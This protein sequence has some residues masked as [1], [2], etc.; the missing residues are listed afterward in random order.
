MRSGSDEASIPARLTPVVRGRGEPRA[1]PLDGLRHRRA[2]RF[3]QRTS[4]LRRTPGIVERTA[5]QHLDLGIEASELICCPAG[6]ASWTAGSILTRMLTF[7]RS[8]SGRIHER[9]V[10]RREPT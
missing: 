1:V 5:Q 2:A 3:R 8:A 10:R 7:R 9:P 4:T 6:Q